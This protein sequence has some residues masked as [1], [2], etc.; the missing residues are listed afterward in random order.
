M[1]FHKF[2]HVEDSA[3]VP[4]PHLIWMGP[5]RIRFHALMA[6]NISKILEIDHDVV[7]T[8]NGVDLSLIAAQ[9]HVLDVWA[10]ALALHGL[11]PSAILP[12]SL[13]TLIRTEYNPLAYTSTADGAFVAVS[14]ECDMGKVCLVINEIRNKPPSGILEDCRLREGEMDEEWW[15]AEAELIQKTNNYLAGLTRDWQHRTRRDSNGR[16]VHCQIKTSPVE[17]IHN[18]PENHLTNGLVKEDFWNRPAENTYELRPLSDGG[19]ELFIEMDDVDAPWETLRQNTRSEGQFR[20]AYPGIISDLENCGPAQKYPADWHDKPEGMI[21]D[22]LFRPDRL[23]VHQEI[24][25]PDESGRLELL[26]FTLQDEDNWSIG[27]DVNLEELVRLTKNLSGAKLNGIIKTATLFSF[28]WHTEIAQLAAVKQEVEDMKLN[29]S[30]FMQALTEV[31]HAYG[32]S[33]A[34][35]EEAVRL[36]IIHHT[37]ALMSTAPF[38]R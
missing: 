25:L 28:S 5:P 38:G 10:A 12:P 16:G 24:S 19:I 17:V 33:E 34:G 11:Q 31:R 3:H 2:F 37:T 6:R 14:S 23:E 36:S 26:K 35:L 21:D 30:A 7:L 27:P 29:R 15:E 1:P 8:N 18:T 20:D 9:W 22:P 4:F 13:I 32:V